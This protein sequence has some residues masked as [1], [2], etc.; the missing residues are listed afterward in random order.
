M[1]TT[2]YDGYS[3]QTLE[4]PPGKWRALISRLDGKD[5]RWEGGTKRTRAF[6]TKQAA[7]EDQARE[8]ARQAIDEGVVSVVE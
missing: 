3:I 2:E 5:V 6:E 4:H 8:F 1:A 7:T